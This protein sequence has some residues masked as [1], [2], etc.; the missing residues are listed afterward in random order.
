MKVCRLRGDLRHLIG[1]TD[2]PDDV[3][4]LHKVHL[5][6]ASSIKADC[7]AGGSVTHLGHAPVDGRVERAILLGLGPRRGVLRGWKPL[8]S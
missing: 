7:S 2:I 3:G 4:P 5:F 6:G 8:A 1:R